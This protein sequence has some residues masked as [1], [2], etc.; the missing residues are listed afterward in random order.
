[1]LDGI[2]RALDRLASWTPDREG[3]A[4]QGLN[5]D[6]VLFRLVDSLLDLF[7]AP[8]DS[9][10]SAYYYRALLCVYRINVWSYLR[11]CSQSL[12]DGVRSSRVA[13][14]YLRLTRRPRTSTTSPFPP[15]GNK[16]MKKAA[17]PHLIPVIL[18]NLT[19]RYDPR[20]DNMHMG[21]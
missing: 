20:P 1:M 19:Q 17:G 13:I 21:T 15:A 14:G 18:S 10:A 4:S 11:I 3:S 5:R 9:S 2:S 7:E 8:E 6:V 16:I 12:L